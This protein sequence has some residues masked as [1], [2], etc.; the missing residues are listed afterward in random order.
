LGAPPWPVFGL[1]KKKG[2]QKKKKN[3]FGWGRGG[4]RVGGHDRGEKLFTRP[5]YGLGVFSWFLGP[6]VRFLNQK[7]GFWAKK[8][9]N[10]KK[11]RK[12]V[13]F[14]FGEFLPRDF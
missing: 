2:L 9:K 5:K 13:I 6:R 10:K 3:S 14:P 4:E 1:C 8:P 7:V 12:L 11:L